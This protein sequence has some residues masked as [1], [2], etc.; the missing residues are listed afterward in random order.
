MSPYRR[1]VAITDLSLAASIAAAA[2]LAWLVW[3][4]RMRPLVEQRRRLEAAFLERTS[5]LANEKLRAQELLEKAEEA[6]RVK[7]EFLASMSHEIRTPMNGVLGMIAIMSSTE[8]S[9]EQREYLET[10]HSSAEAL[11]SLLN[12]VLDISRMEAGRLELDQQELAPEDV[13]RG[14]ADALATRAIQKGLDLR[15]EIA[16]GFPRA[17]FGDPARLRQVLLN[18]IGNAIKFTESGRVL[19]RAESTPDGLLLFSVSDTGIGI[20]ADKQQI[21]FEEFR[22]ADGSDTR[23]YGGAG[24]GLGISAKLVALMGGRIWV[25]SEVGC[26]STFHFTSRLERVPEIPRKPPALA[27]PENGYR[28]FNILVAEDNPVNQKVA[29]RLLEKMGHKISL[30]SNGR[31]ALEAS[32]RGSFDLVLMDVQMPEMDGLEATRHIRERERETGQHLPIVAMT[33]YAMKGDRERCLAAGMDG[34]ISK[35]VQSHELARIIQSGA[36]AAGASLAS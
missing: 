23:C 7:S 15:V 6:S 10:A 26:G 34:Y 29:T 35:P 4:L 27:M 22:Q 33:A 21:I 12:D 11:L 16:P 1:H 13:V 20:P 36:A 28:N 31:E 9:P 30:V 25:E 17:V 3:W 19:V 24:L 14:A 5:E 18:L 32:A 2:A 8:L